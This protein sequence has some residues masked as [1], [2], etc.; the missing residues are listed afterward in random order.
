M[1]TTARLESA[2][3]LRTRRILVR[4]V[5]VCSLIILVAGL[6]PFRFHPPNGARWQRNE[7]GISFDGHGMVFS[8]EPLASFLTSPER[9]AA[10]SFTIEL[11][12][13]PRAQDRSHLAHI[14]SDHSSRRAS[15]LVL[16]Q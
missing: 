4:F 13:R 15:G 8:T 3:S 5:V 2:A 9:E 7:D 16:A 14:L 12:V 10:A 6:W 11:L 1:S